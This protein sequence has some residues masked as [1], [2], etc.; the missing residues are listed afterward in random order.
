MFSQEQKDC[1]W[2]KV[3]ITDDITQCW[4]WRG[5]KNTKGYG[6][7]RIS[8]RHLLS[9][10]V[11]FEFAVCEIPPAL[12]VCHLCDNPPCCNPRH[13]VLG[14]RCANVADMIIKNR[15]GFKKNRAI[16]TRNF[17]A[18]LNDDSVKEIRSAYA[19]GEMNQYELADK[20]GVTQ[21]AIGSVVLNRTWR[22]I[23]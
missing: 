9:H 16:G 5:A 12:I 14:T 3:E 18:K 10:R 22:H 23:A 1:F 17:N 7:V 20:Y 4:A 21:T 19:R 8:K 15:Q 11:A 2:S 13:L 6:H